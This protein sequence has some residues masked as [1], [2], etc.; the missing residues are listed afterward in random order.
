MSKN[1][2]FFVFI[3]IFLFLIFANIL[4]KAQDT[5]LPPEVKGVEKLQN[6]T[7][8]LTDEETREEYLKQEW[9]KILKE[10]KVVAA[11]DS[12]CTKYSI[13]F[14]IVFGM[15]YSLSLTLVF[16]IVLWLFIALTIS[17]ITRKGLGF[18]EGLSYILGIVAAVVLAQLQILRR[19]SAFLVELII[20]RE[21]FWARFIVFMIIIAILILLYYFKGG[22]SQALE[23]RRKKLKEE[24]TEQKQKEIKKFTENLEKGVGI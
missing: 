13:F 20:S 14:R 16:V 5:Y 11:I 1:K 21:A 18:L 17:D 23:Q 8:K 7:E 10:N 19:F 22:L 6:I 12:F 9:Q 24:E 4:I 15:P 2:L 3:I